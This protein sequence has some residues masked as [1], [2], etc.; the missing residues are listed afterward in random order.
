MILPGK[1]YKA[2]QFS[3]DQQ[4]AVKKNSTAANGQHGAKYDELIVAC[5]ARLTGQRQEKTTNGWARER[6]RR[7][8]QKHN[9]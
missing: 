1:S 4:T 7:A 9:A 2:S 8:D 6:A 5:D 3:G